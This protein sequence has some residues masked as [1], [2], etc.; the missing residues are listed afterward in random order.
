MRRLFVY[1]LGKFLAYIMPLRRISLPFGSI[2]LNP[3]PFNIK[4]NTL[5]IIMANVIVSPM[6][7]ATSAAELY[8]GAHLRGGS[9]PYIDK[10]KRR[11]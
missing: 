10:G 1:P 11:C 3:G 5:I 6:L 8:L 7:H 4:E 9:V 2:D